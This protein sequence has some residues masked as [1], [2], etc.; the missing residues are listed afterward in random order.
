MLADYTLND[1]GVLIECWLFRAWSLKASSS[2][3]ALN[4]R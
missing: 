2:D 3:E 4:R 1:P